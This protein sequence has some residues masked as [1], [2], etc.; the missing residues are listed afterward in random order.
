MRVQRRE[1]RLPPS[2]WPT[3]PQNK[4][5]INHPKTVDFSKHRQR[6]LDVLCA[7]R[8][9]LERLP[10]PFVVF[11]MRL[12]RSTPLYHCWFSRRTLSFKRDAILSIRDANG[13]LLFWGSVGQVGCFNKTFTRLSPGRRVWL[14]GLHKSLT[15]ASTG[16]EAGHR[17][18]SLVGA[19]KRRG[20]V[21]DTLPPGLT[22]AA[23]AAALGP[24]ATRGLRG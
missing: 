14:T 15:E 4:A 9:R 16:R 24:D 8:H 5:H 3:S 1:H 11:Q 7:N 22:P 13:L 17:T 10:P 18:R 19:G 21:A 2:A 20:H 23:A 6:E 12:V